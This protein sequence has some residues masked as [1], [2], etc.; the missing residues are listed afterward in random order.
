MMRRGAGAV[1]R[2]GLENR[3]PSCG[4]PRVRIPPSPPTYKKLLVRSMT[5]QKFWGFKASWWYKRE[6][7]SGLP[8]HASALQAP[9]DRRLLL[10]QGRPAAP[11]GSRRP[12]RVSDQPPHEG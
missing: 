9:E 8:I 10:S 2:G 7:Q 12:H 6:V 1:D 11:S 3:C 5:W 4:G